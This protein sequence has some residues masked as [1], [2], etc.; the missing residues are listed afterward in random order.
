MLMCF[1]LVEDMLVN[2]DL[3]DNA[4]FSSHSVNS[5]TLVVSVFLSFI[6]E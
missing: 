4:V 6:S 5:D 2:V 1:V 3:L